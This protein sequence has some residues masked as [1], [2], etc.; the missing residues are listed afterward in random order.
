LGKRRSNITDTEL[1]LPADIDGILD[2]F[3]SY[4]KSYTRLAERESIFANYKRSTKKLEVLFP[5]IEH[6]IHG[7]TGL[8]VVENY[9]DA[10]FVSKYHYQWKVIVPK[11]GI[12]TSHISGWGNDSHH[13]VTTPEEYKVKTEP[14][15]HHYD[16]SD[17]KKRRE[18]YDVRSLQ[19]V[20]KF[21]ASYLD[22]GL[23]YTG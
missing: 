4:L 11:M 15:H 21:V 20:F 9:N 7:I 12:Q 1:L 16:P 8:H 22:S 5:L 13:A 19:Q 14:H 3:G 2:E 6:P 17:R 23:Q 18:N 10:G